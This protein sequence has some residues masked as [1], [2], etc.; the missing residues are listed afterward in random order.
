MDPVPTENNNGK[1]SKD[2][3]RYR[4]RPR[5]AQVCQG[6]SMFQPPEACSSVLG[7]VSPHGWCRYW[8][9]KRAGPFAAG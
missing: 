9:A 3:A 6:C 5:G 8:A 2:E 4:D 1:A 7:T